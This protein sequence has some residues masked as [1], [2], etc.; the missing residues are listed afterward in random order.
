[1]ESDN[2]HWRFQ[3]STIRLNPS[4]ELEVSTYEKS[5]MDA[6]LRDLFQKPEELAITQSKQKI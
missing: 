4:G 5:Q 2:E 1:L 3:N 6:E